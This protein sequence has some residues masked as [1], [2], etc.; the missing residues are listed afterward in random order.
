[1]FL[2]A[3]LDLGDFKLALALDVGLIRTVHHDVAD[4]GIGE[5]FL[6]RSETQ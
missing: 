3:E 5:E 4:R 6:E 1:M 2:V